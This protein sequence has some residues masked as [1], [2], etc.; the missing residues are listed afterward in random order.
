MRRAIITIEVLIALV[1]IFAAIVLVSSTARSLAHFSIRKERYID[2]YVTILSLAEKLHNEPL[3]QPETI[4]GT[5]NG[6]DFTLDCRLAHSRKTY[7]VTE[8][9][10]SGNI[11]DFLVKLYHCTIS[12]E[13]EGDLID[14]Q[15]LSQ[16]RYEKAVP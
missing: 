1:I 13:K 7:T 12:L 16:I 10:Q 8:E 5:L 11:G 3:K 4:N 9:G 14:T 2:R 15:T 6:F